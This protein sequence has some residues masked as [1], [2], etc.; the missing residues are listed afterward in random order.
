MGPQVLYQG[1][2]RLEKEKANREHLEMEIDVVST[3]PQ[4]PLAPLPP[5]RGRE[6]GRL[7]LVRAGDSEAAGKTVQAA[8]GMLPP[9]AALSCRKRTKALLHQK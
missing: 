8:G 6:V 1:I 5:V 9:H 2:E 4:G 3:R 7:G